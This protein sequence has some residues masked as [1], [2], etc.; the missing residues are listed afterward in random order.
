VPP[1]PVLA[2]AA[3]RWKAKVDAVLGEEIGWSKAGIEKDTP[4]M[5]RWIAGAIRA[6]MGTD[7]AIVNVNGLRQSLPRGPVTKASVWSILPFDNQVVVVQLSGDALA[8]NLRHKEAVIAGATRDAQGGFTLAGG[9]PLDPK[10][11]YTV[12]TV[13]YLYFGGDHFTFQQ[14]ARAADV[15]HADWR[16]VV[17]G[18]TQRQ[19][20]SREAPLEARLPP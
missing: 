13:D 8:E 11:V 15:K 17:I 9:R 1:D 20:T 14:H 5:S 7:V 18:W 3:E 6:E 4:E 19:R 12:A 16:D 10:G 2:S